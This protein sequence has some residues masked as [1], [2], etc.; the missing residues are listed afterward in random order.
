MQEVI[1]TLALRSKLPSHFRDL[2]ALLEIQGK[3]RQQSNGPTI[4]PE[5]GKIPSF[6]TLFLGEGTGRLLETCN[7]VTKPS[8]HTHA[9]S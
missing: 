7:I 9:I 2:Y 3:G 1:Y 8:F 4:F 6:R 5:S